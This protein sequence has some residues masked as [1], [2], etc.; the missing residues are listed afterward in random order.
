[1]FKTVEQ[2]TNYYQF[3]QGAKEPDL[4]ISVT[5]PEFGII[6]SVLDLIYGL[7][8]NKRAFLQMGT[9]A[10]RAA[11]LKK[12]KTCAASRCDGRGDKV[13]HE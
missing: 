6:K 5:Y 4:I 10:W 2:L 13:I 11:S 12:V 1:M 8:G 9:Q 3:S 7:E